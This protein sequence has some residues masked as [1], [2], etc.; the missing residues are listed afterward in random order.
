MPDFYH[1]SCFEEV[2]D[3]SQSAFLNRIHPITRATFALRGVKATSIMDGHYLVDGGAE[4]LILQWKV[5]RYHQIYER[6]GIADDYAISDDFKDLLDNA[7]LPDF[8]GRRV[9]RLFDDEH[10]ALTTTLA[11]TESD[12]TE[13]HHPWNLFE[14]ISPLASLGA[15]P[16]ATP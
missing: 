10:L 4:R 13:D 12:G 14:T 15:W 5:E 2:A 8:K 9:D 11:P 7:G 6:D 1:V 3:L 16:T